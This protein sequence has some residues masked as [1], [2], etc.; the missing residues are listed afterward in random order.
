LKALGK[1]LRHLLVWWLPTLLL[2]LAMLVGAATW[3]L[4][5]QAGARWLVGTAVW[6]WG[7][8][9]GAQ[10]EDV[11]GSVWAGL[12]IARLAVTISDVAVD[13]RDL[14]VQI[15]WTDL[16]QRRL[17]IRELS[18]ADLSIVLSDSAPTSDP[19]GGSDEAVSLPLDI[20]LERLSIGT[21]DL[22]L[23][24]QPLPVTVS[25][26]LA[27]LS[28]DAQG[29]R[30]RVE[31]LHVA[32]A[33]AQAD[34]QGQADLKQLR[35]P[36]P[37]SARVHVAMRATAADSPV[38]VG[39]FVSDVMPGPKDGSKPG[40]KPASKPASK[41]GSR[42]IA[43]PGSPSV[44][45]PAA[46]TAP[47]TAAGRVASADARAPGSGADA[48]VIDADLRLDGSL[49][50]LDAALTAQGGGA[51]LVVQ[52][53]LTPQGHLPLRRATLA[54]ELPDRTAAAVSLDI[55]HDD[56]AAANRVHGS[57]TVDRLDLGRLL[58]GL[59]PPAL[60]STRGSFDAELTDRYV[61]REAGIDLGIDKGSRWN[62]QALEGTARARVV[63]AA[64]RDPSADW[65]AAL[66]DIRVEA[67]GVDLRLGRNRLRAQGN[68]GTSEGAITL[69][70]A[71]PELAAFWP[72]LGGAATL[73]GKLAGTPAR[74]RLELRGAYTPADSRAGIL[75]RAQVVAS[76]NLEGAYGAG[77][78]TDAAARELGWR[79]T[80]SRLSISQAGFD[81]AATRPVTLAYLPHAAA[82]LWQ[83]QVGAGRIEMSLPGGDRMV[84]DHAG[85]RGG[86]GRWETAG[87]MD[88]AVFTPA[89]VRRVMRALDPDAAPA[90][91]AG[92]TGA[93]T[94]GNTRANT[95]VNA[96]VPASQ[97]RIA[98]DVS[99]D[100][101]YAGSLG[102][103]A[104]VAR[105]SGDLLVPGD[106]PMALGL[107]NLVLD[108]SATPV[109]GRGSRVDA[110]LQVDTAAMGS[111][112][113]TGAAMLAT[114][115][116]GT[117]GLAPRQPVRVSL[118]ADISD[119]KWVEIFTGDNMEVGGAL[120]ASVQVQG[121]PGGA[122]QTSGTV[123]GEKLR[124]VRIDDG[125]RLLDGTLSARLQDGSLIVDSLRFPA[126]LRVIPTEARTRDWVTRDPDAKN[127]YVEASGTWSLMQN[128]G[129]A[130]V[131]LRRFPVIQRADRFAMMSGR[132][133]I[134]ATLPHMTIRGDIKADA[135]WASLEV[136]SEVPTLDGDVIVHRPGD[137]DQAAATPLQTDMDLNVDLGSRFYITGMGLDAAL[138]GSIRIRYIEGR[139]TG[140][141]AL[142]TRAGRIDAYGQRLQL[143]RGTVTF[144]GS[145]D[146]PLLDI[147]ALRT[148]EQVE[149][150]VRVSGTAQRPRIDLI[151]YPDV[152]D[153]EK[154]SWLVLGRAPDASGSDTALLVSVG[155]ALLGNG[156]PF[157]KQFGLDDVSIR[158]GD[159]GTSSSLLPD[160]TVA[161]NVNQDTTGALATQFLV[162]SKNFADGV[163]LSV[164]QALSGSE[165][166]GRL[167]YRLSRRWSVDLKGGA[168][169][170]LD[171]VYRTF[172]ED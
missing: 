95:R 159:I 50:G 93:N 141:G 134:D 38:C 158:S 19:A 100:L 43:K 71:A 77:T 133:D 96:R 130:H 41:P 127:G 23:A 48:C 150:G 79:G 36:W 86:A 56:A 153:V 2:L 14:A 57:I 40:S 27:G 20:V 138:A 22:R 70:A 69:D 75:G 6:Q 115:P 151:S 157:Y 4:G 42:T 97:R 37:L 60:L 83:W 172:L 63:T 74:H 162:A 106:P 103:R 108:M 16:L 171:L 137:S 102:G 15:A 161:G 17:R 170:G 76:L 121:V 125:V 99:W 120:K 166:V 168:V 5:T 155:T 11:Q 118:D 160:Q 116:D 12:R 58:G 114:N 88:D 26:L 44:A 13:A 61:L 49:A 28:A 119:L 109:S 9:S 46:D 59:V 101:R 164:E 117:I 129:Q 149:A 126:T 131:V 143:R 148:G 146:N 55:T 34:V 123:R 113:G 81:L 92:N 78:G 3:A 90:A 98:L 21:F 65:P 136:L 82:P 47:D 128:T 163:T 165:T 66:A 33:L 32:H 31:T 51:A 139:L 87:R 24:G 54:L 152:S 132:I 156:Q 25:N 73:Q 8:Q 62:R 104:R 30:L 91:Q 29:A 110:T 89:M 80:V 68:I 140:T 64:K 154:L 10:A 111:L 167:S 1:V 144:Q 45:K 169:N 147:E 124:W 85:S 84:L 122:W 112:R 35:A 39:R 53:E 18:A 142:H 145:L 94:G 107:R 67:M 72:G 105:R 7:G 135:G 52:A